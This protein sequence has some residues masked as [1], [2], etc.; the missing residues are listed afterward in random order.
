M[1]SDASGGRRVDGRARW[2]VALAVVL[3]NLVQQPGR[4]TFDT[5]LDLQ[6]APGE[7]LARSL[8]LWNPDSALGELQNQASGYLFPLGPVYLV[9]H[10]LHVPAWVWERGVSALV[11]IAAFEGMRRLARG[12][13][14]L[15]E[16]PALFAGLFYML[17]PRLVSTVGALNGE[18]LPGA[19][20]PWTVLPIVLCLRGRISAR[21]A[22]L[23][24][25]ATIP[26]MGG[27]NATEVLAALALPAVLL[28][29]N[30]PAWRT[31]V[32]LLAG[33]TGG[34]VLVSLW[35]LVPLVMLG[36]YGAPFLDYVESARNTTDRIGWLAALRGTD[37]WVTFIAL[38]DSTS[39]RAGLQL[40][41]SPVL[42]VSTTCAAV[43][44]LLGLLSPR[45]PR[46]RALVVALVLGLFV[47]T[48]GSGLPAGSILDGVWTAALDGALAPFRN[49]HKFDP[50]V[51][52]PL[53]LGFGAAVAF[54]RGWAAAYPVN[55]RRIGR[56][57]TAALVVPVLMAGIPMVEGH[58]RDS[59][60]FT[61]LP[62]SWRQAVRYLEERPG[63]VRSLVIP[64]SGFAV[65]TWGRTIDEPMQVLSTEPWSARTQ[66][67][68]MPAG[69]IRWLDMVEE[70][71]SAGR[72]DPAFAALLAR[73]GITHLVV[74]ND[75]DYRNTDSPPPEIVHRLLDHT[76]GLVEVARFGRSE[77]TYPAVEVYA[78]RAAGDPRARLLDA[79]DAV[80]VAGG[81]EAVDQ[82]LDQHVLSDD[83]AMLRVVDGA[84]PVDAVTDTLQ[85]VERAFGGLHDVTSQVMTATDPYRT[86]RAAHDYAYQRSTPP[87]VASYTGISGI[88]ASSSRGYVDTL[89]GVHPDQ[90]PY[91]AVDG[92]LLAS[93]VAS[94]FSQPRGTWIELEFAAPTVLGR[95][96]V[97][98]DVDNGAGVRTVALDTDSGRVTAQVDR[99]GQVVFGMGTAPTRTA[100]LTVLSATK[101]T[102]PVSLE[103]ISIDGVP[104]S[105]ALVVPVAVGA[106][107]TISL[108]S[109]EPRGACVPFNAGLSCRA[110]YQRLSVEGAR[111]SREVRV[112]ERGSWTVAG[113]VVAQ[114]GEGVAALMRPLDPR[115]VRVDASSWYGGDAATVPQNA[116]DGEPT[117]TWVAAPSDDHPV[118]DLSW[119][120]RVRITRVVPRLLA[121]APG[122]LP[123]RIRVES[124]QGTQVV[125]V[126][127]LA[128]GLID[129]IRTSHLRLTLL[130]DQ[131]VSHDVPLAI[132]ELTIDGLEHRTYHA[133]YRS[134]TGTLCGFGPRIEVGGTTVQTRIRG[135]IGDLLSGAPM[136]IEACGSADGTVDLDP[137]TRRV[138]VVNAD[139]FSVRDLVLR[140]A[141]RSEITARSGAS[142]VLRW[143][144]TSRA[145]RID[146]PVPALLAVTQSLNPGWVA[147]LHG[148]RLAPVELDGWMQGWRIPAG[149][150]GV[151]ELRFTPQTPYLLSLLGGF[152]IALLVIAL[153]AVVALR[154]PR[155]GARLEEVHDE[156]PLRPLLAALALAIL[157]VVS[158]PAGIGA[159]VGLGLRRL[160][161][162]ARVIGLLVVL[163]AGAATVLGVRGLSTSLAAPVAADVLVSFAFGLLAGWVVDPRPGP[164]RSPSGGAHV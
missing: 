145:V 151:V 135:T 149:G 112:A 51:R 79:R 53:A 46:R 20:L 113:T 41:S 15:G 124:D 143:G 138:T 92:S 32:R 117:S 109:P 21:R 24:S 72:P 8:H 40:V 115:K 125:T 158:L 101:S 81:A 121:G 59:G 66:T 68:L 12:W 45:L 86:Q 88:R 36:R 38:G 42:L 14:G 144:A 162:S 156:T 39:W 44:G 146:T 108:R 147:T 35:W 131:N 163:C 85:R 67:P 52:V 77:T 141:T 137:G 157:V 19:V 16:G 105:R 37:H 75:L 126:G 28:V 139:G 63:V 4:T 80:T 34:A 78:V 123:D 107:T 60:G 89:G 136:A 104:I 120:G 55:G 134:G 128:T 76:A 87:T 142:S 5:K 84:Q 10:L 57:A 26:F 122:R 160:S 150:T 118:L 61:D 82:L 96:T 95:T 2:A 148:K 64:G 62:Q 94:P 164:D 114:G 30:A 119:Q 49:V 27:Q 154:S 152:S 1:A 25:V 48:A 127:R 129:P 159:G 100:R 74:R 69:T 70:A 18:A 98:F 111:W 58:L 33:W 106:G 29:V 23:L 102:R 7:F 11:M 6:I 130:R 3:L 47:L 133:D 17:S 43:V 13:G 116:F 9:G 65:Q 54:A 90:G 99:R 83:S 155:P 93:W 31:K 71:V 110:S 50:V 132:S 22:V 103:E 140:P 73:A 91:A 161:A 97:Q 153:A 56:L